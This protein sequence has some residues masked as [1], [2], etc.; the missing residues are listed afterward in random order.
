M[1]LNGSDD[2]LEN[3]SPNPL[4]DTTANV[5]ALK[6][7]CDVLTARDKI[8]SSLYHFLLPSVSLVTAILKFPSLRFVF[9]VI[10]NT[11]CGIRL[12]NT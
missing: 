2:V 3:A 10:L 1:Q 12:L 8:Q 4:K 11:C 7:R 9:V 6:C 5:D